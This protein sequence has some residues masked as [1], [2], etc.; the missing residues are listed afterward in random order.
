MPGRKLLYL[1]R[2]PIDAASR[3]ALFPQS[4]ASSPQ[5]DIS[6]VLLNPP[7]A[8]V[9]PVAGHKMYVLH[10]ESAAPSF[11][12]GVSTLSYHD[13]LSLIFEVDSTIIL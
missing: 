5:D 10:G 7:A 6:M 11:S 13:L 4:T 12:G 1:L 9:T 2:T 3:S 8:G